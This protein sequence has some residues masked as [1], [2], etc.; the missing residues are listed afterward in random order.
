MRR[1]TKRR[2]G[3]AALLAI[4]AAVA[5]VV[6]VGSARADSPNNFTYVVNPFLQPAD[7]GDGTATFTNPFCSGGTLVCYTPNDIKTAYNYPSG[8]TGA[9]QTIVI[10][11]AYGSP[12]VQEDLAAF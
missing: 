1:L 11:D 6:A 5:A 9:G 10:V 4:A 12:T 8:L 2:L 7:N 3:S